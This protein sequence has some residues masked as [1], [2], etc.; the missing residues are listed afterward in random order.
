MGTGIRPVQIARAKKSDV[1]E[2]T[3]PEGREFTLLITLA[4]T[5]EAKKETRW[6][7]KCQTQLAEVLQAYLSTAEMKEAG[8]QAP[9]FYDNSQ[10][11]QQRLKLIFD[12]LET[13]SDR[14]DGPIPL[15]PYSVD[16]TA[17]KVADD[18]RK[19]AR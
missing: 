6:R 13:H 15:F 1:I 14:L 19:L 16:A 11:V 3:G 18:I 12:G 17:R 10:T 4:K 2:T 9:L 7:R 8:P 5:R